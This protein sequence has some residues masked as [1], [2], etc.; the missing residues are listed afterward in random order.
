MAERV[1]LLELRN[2][3]VIS[4]E[5]LLTLE[6]ELDLEAARHGLAELR[7]VETLLE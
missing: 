4:D 1:A 2:Q 7:R 5:V 6:S 3:D